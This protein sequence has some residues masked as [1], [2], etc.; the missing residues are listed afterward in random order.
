MAWLREHVGLSTWVVF[1]GA[2]ISAAGGLLVFL[3]EATGICLSIALVVIV[4]IVG[5]FVSAAGALMSSGERAKHEREIAKV[6]KDT[7]YSVTGGDSFCYVLIAGQGWIIIQ[8]GDYPVYDV[9]VRITYLRGFQREVAAG[10]INPLGPHTTNLTVENLRP[11]GSVIMGK[12]QPQDD[13]KQG[14]NVFISARNGLFTEEL[15]LTYE[16]SEPKYA[17]RVKRSL[18]LPNESPVLYEYVQGGFP[19]NDKGGVEWGSAEWG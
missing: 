6:S 11:G 18:P 1:A 17:V 5:A 14:Y 2:I 12:R 10:V 8:K 19:T 15:R 7:L 3:C 4:V 13:I 9:S 16:G